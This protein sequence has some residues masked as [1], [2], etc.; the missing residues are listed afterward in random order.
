MSFPLQSFDR[1]PTPESEKKMEQR[2]TDKSEMSFPV[3]A[4]YEIFM[5][6]VRCY[7]QVYRKTEGMHPFQ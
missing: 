1:Y 6:R 7:T 2:T 5:E 4:P 3:D